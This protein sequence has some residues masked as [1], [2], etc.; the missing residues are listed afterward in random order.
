MIDGA[1]DEQHGHRL[2]EEVD[3]VLQEIGLR[4]IHAADVLACGG[5]QDLL[6]QERSGRILQGCGRHRVWVVGDP[7]QVLTQLHLG[8]SIMAMHEISELVVP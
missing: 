2:A 1:T 3:T 8:G 6:R 7:V 4:L 5:R